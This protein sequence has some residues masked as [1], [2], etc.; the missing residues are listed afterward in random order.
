MPPRLFSR[1]LESRAQ[2]LAMLTETG[3][4]QGKLALSPVPSSRDNTVVE[5]ELLDYVDYDHKPMSLALTEFHFILLFDFKWQ[6]N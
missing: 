5:A 6:V 4:Y 3:I 2:S 1:P